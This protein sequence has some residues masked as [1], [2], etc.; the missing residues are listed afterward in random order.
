MMGTV[1]KKLSVWKTKFVENNAS[2]NIIKEVAE[3]M[4]EVTINS[5]YGEE[6]SH[7]KTDYE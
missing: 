4:E 3:L 7:M 5:I 2:F 6:F 1:M